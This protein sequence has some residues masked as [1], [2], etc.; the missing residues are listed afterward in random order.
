M[1]L[2]GFLTNLV[3]PPPLY[4]AQLNEMFFERWRAA[5][6]DGGRH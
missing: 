6:G 3:L 5:A 1:W 2:F 4:V